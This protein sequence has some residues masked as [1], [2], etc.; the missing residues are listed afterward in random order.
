MGMP[1]CTAGGRGTT[2]KSNR[3]HNVP[4]MRNKRRAKWAEQRFFEDLAKQKLAEAKEA[5]EQEWAEEWGN[6][7]Y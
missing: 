2:V 5:R 3:V 7:E 1:K 6:D 4:G